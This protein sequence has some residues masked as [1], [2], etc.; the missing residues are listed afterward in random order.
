MRLPEKKNV[1]EAVLDRLSAT[2]A[3]A[4]ESAQ[5]TREGATHAE[6][7]PENDKDTRALEQSY[8][9]RGQAMRVEELAEQIQKLRFFVVGSFGEDDAID[10]GALVELESDDASRVVF[11]LPQGGGTEVKVDGVDVLVVTGS[12]P[13]G[14]SLLGK[15]EGDDVEVVVKGVRREYVVAQVR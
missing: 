1:L 8:L 6:A 4:A 15:G 10:L 2:M 3:A 11:L 5:R 14:A 12:S 9:A 13:L 7:K